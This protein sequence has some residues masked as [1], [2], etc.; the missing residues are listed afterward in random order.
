MMDSRRLE[1]RKRQKWLWGLLPA[2]GV[3]TLL[4]ALGVSAA[5][6]NKGCI[7]PP[8]HGT[9]LVFPASSPSVPVTFQGEVDL[10]AR[11]V[12]LRQN[13]LSP[14]STGTA[15]A[16]N[17][18]DLGIATPAIDPK[19]G[20]NK[21][22]ITFNIPKSRWPE[23]D[24][25]S[26]SGSQELND[27][28]RNLLVTVNTGLSVN[29]H[30]MVGVADQPDDGNFV[31]LAALPNTVRL[32][33][34]ENRITF[35]K[36]KG[37]PTPSDA[38]YNKIN[39]PV[40]F[41]DWKRR[42][43]FDPAPANEFVTYYRNENDLG[44]GREMHCRVITSGAFGTSQ[45]AAC[46]VT[47][48]ANEDQAAAGTN[49][50]ATVGMDFDVTRSDKV[51][52]Y[53]YKNPE[54]TRKNAVALD[55]EGE[56]AVP[57]MCLN[58]HGGRVG[59]DGLVNGAHFLPFDTT[60]LP[61]PASKGPQEAAFKSQNAIVWSVEANNAQNSAIRTLIEG[62]YTKTN[63]DGTKTVGLFDTTTPFDRL[64]APSGFANNKGPYLT[65]VAPYCRTC[66]AAQDGITLESES[67]LRGLAPRI[68][69]VVCDKDGFRPGG[70]VMPHAQRTYQKFW[71]S[72]ARAVI[73]ID[74]GLA[75]C[76]FQ[77]GFPTN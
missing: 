70:T 7:G 64:F 33:G 48:Y 16:S 32:P 25:T 28:T 53:V 4:M 1:N 36:R 19:D 74:L 72:G 35:L 49:A 39:A 57:N 6:M 15:S 60:F 9:S 51:R 61:T 50:I 30:F 54:G 46:Y 66:H 8:L 27:G 20:K 31:N 68:K 71:Q 43:G 13:E 14:S 10:T 26:F 55:G 42:F 75:H 69:E 2:S 47:N 22:A 38:Y 45:K 34:D 63:P 24:V 56:K 77:P 21:Y 29:N 11:R 40:T 73:A 76:K 37:L 58:C 41:A 59:S 23:D 52:F 3:A 44:F 65:M 5:A 67:E 12:I 62:W 18:T 17:F